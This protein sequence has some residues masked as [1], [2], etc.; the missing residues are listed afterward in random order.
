MQDRYNADVHKAL[1]EISKELYF[2]TNELVETNQRLS[3]IVS[4]LSAYGSKQPQNQPIPP[5]CEE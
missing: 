4:N 1:V 5:K 2:I 3:I